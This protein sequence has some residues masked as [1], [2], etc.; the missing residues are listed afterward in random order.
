MFYASVRLIKN[1]VALQKFTPKLGALLT[2]LLHHIRLAQ[3][4]TGWL[5]NTYKDPKGLLSCVVRLSSEQNTL[6]QAFKV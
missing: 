4:K 3:L 1:V 5:Y 6:F 2:S